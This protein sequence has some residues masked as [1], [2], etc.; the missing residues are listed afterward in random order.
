ME[1]Q[2]D[3][4]L[5]PSTRW[6]ALTMTSDGRVTSP[7][8]LLDANV[9]VIGAGFA[10]LCA[11]CDLVA[12]GF[13]VQAFEAAGFPIGTERV[14]ADTGYFETC[15]RP[16]VALADLRATPL[17]TATASGLRT[18]KGHHE[19]SGIVFSAGFDAITVRPFSGPNPR[20][21]GAAGAARATGARPPEI[22]WSGHRHVPQVRARR[23]GSLALLTNVVASIEEQVDW[24]VHYLRALRCQGRR[25]T[26]AR[27]AAEDDWGRQ[28]LAE[29]RTLYPEAASWYNGA[30]T[31]GKTRQ[32]MI[33][34]RGPS[35]YA[36]I[37]AGIARQGF[38]P[39]SGNAEVCQM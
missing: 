36:R 15:N 31:P 21:W 34:L 37:F 23:H 16:N 5:Y 18:S 7:A 28:L 6:P 12:A 22:S 29:A 32:F 20:R 35:N 14:Y 33:Y 27:E 24:L 10:D 17:V 8:R 1:P 38:T 4:S 3:D 9:I 13:S 26:V 39:V 11:V 30:N 19:L 2:Y 25:E